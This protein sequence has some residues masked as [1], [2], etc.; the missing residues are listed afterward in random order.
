[1]KKIYLFAVVALLALASCNRNSFQIGSACHREIEDEVFKPNYQS[2]TTVEK[3]F[4]MIDTTYKF[5]AVIDEIGNQMKLR[6]YEDSKERPN[7][8][9]FYA[10]F[11]T[12]VNL[13]V[14]QRSF[15][16]LGKENMNEELRRVKL[17]KGTLLLQF[18]ENDSN[19]PIWMGY[20]AGI[21]APETHNIDEK[22][23]RIATRQIFDNYRIFAKDYIAGKPVSAQTIALK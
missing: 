13:S 23:L 19:R 21:A 11:P 4:T 2:F 8:I 7:L 5:Q 12:D 18:V 22:A 9:V 16:G 17:R 10:L 15:R 14:L 3:Q 1:M 6:G 20:A